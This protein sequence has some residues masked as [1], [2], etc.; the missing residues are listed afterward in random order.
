MGWRWQEWFATRLRPVLSKHS[1]IRDHCRVETVDSD[2][3][4]VGKVGVAV[5]F[6][7]AAAAAFVDLVVA[8]AVAVEAVRTSSWAAGWM[9]AR[10]S[11]KWLFR[12]CFQDGTV[13]KIKVPW[14]SSS[15]RAG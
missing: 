4:A 2:E 10:G 11:S 7:A 8:F 3:A 5:D 14:V 15:R 12:N 13:G 1:Q 6:A 9:E